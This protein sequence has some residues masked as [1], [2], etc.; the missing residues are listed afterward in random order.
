MYLSIYLLYTTSRPIAE[1]KQLVV[2]LLYCCWIKELRLCTIDNWTGLV[3]CSIH[4]SL[5][6]SLLN[7]L[8][9][10]NYPTWSHACHASKAVIQNIKSIVQAIQA[11]GDNRPRKTRTNLAYCIMYT[12]SNSNCFAVVSDGQQQRRATAVHDNGRWF[13][14]N[15]TCSQLGLY[16]IAA[17]TPGVI[18]S[19]P[20]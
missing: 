17:R 11:C 13:I 1:L 16:I 14:A 4:T 3:T 2:V 8:G 7:L 18:Y 19:C 12:S 10:F 15:H 6:S 20:C 5:L 9:V